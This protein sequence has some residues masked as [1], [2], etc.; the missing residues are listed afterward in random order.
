MMTSYEMAVE[1]A[2]AMSPYAKVRIADGSTRWEACIPT[3]V[4]A[5]STLPDS[6]RGTPAWE[7][8]Q[9]P[10]GLYPNDLLS[11]ANYNKILDKPLEYIA[12]YYNLSQIEGEEM[13]VFAKKFH[14]ETGVADLDWGGGEISNDDFSTYTDNIRKASALIDPI[15]RRN[16]DEK[17]KYLV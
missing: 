6:Y 4:L 8:Y 3:G 11:W 5:P 16:L 14:E 17:W 1:A 12:D 2:K 7:K 13:S 10:N 15:N 9:K